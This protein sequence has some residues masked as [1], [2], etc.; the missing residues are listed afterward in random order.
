MVAEFEVPRPMRPTDSIPHASGMGDAERVYREHATDDEIADVLAQ[1]LV[2][3]IGTLNAGGSIHL[4]YVIFLHAEGRMY[5][6]TS[7]IT[8]KA[9]NAE[10]SPHATMLVQ[11][12]A[13]TGRTLMVSLEGT[14]R[15]IQ[16]AEAHEINHRLRAKYVKA[17]VLP[18]IDRAWGPLDD[19]AVEI[20]P[21]TVRSWSGSVLR[22]VTQMELS[23]PYGEAWLPDDE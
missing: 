7:S 5:F 21:R 15:V 12:Q 22:E 16:G 14:A 6:E 19:V 20:T 10:R 8:R 9:R 4:A 1:R 13:S 11:G 23:V 2:A 3:T 18:D 17:A